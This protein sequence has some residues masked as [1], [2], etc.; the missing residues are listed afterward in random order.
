VTLTRGTATNPPQAAVSVLPVQWQLSSDRNDFTANI[1]FSYTDAELGTADEG[2][3]VVFTS[4]TGAADSWVMAG[5]SQQQDL[6]RNEITVIGIDSFSLF[7]IAAADSN[8]A[9]TAAFSFS[10]TDLNC[11]FTDTS[12]DG[13]VTGWAWDFGDGNSATTQHPAHSYAAGTYTVS[14]TV[15]DN[16]GATHSTSQSLTVSAAS[17]DAVSQSDDAV[18]QIDNG[19]GG[20]CTIRSDASIDSSWLLMIIGFGIGFIRQRLISNKPRLTREVYRCPDAESGR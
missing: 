15:T 8:L 2:R 4:S 6:L 19:G 1:S 18:S 14:L 3:L 13:S 11:N 7:V 17:D 10:C 12:T 20:G 5:N 9:P 16:E